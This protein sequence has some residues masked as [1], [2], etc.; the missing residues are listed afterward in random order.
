MVE[1]NQRRRDLMM[2]LS[3][4]VDKLLSSSFS[5]GLL[6]KTH[7]PECILRAFQEYRVYC[8]SFP[9]FL[10]TLLSRSDDEVVRQPLIINLWEES[11]EG[12]LRKTHLKMLDRFLSSWSE[13]I[14]LKNWEI[15]ATSGTV[16]RKF[17]SDIHSY[18]QTKSLPEVFGFIGPGTE[19][20]TTKQYELF[21]KGLRGYGLVNDGDLEFFTTHLV[22]DVRHADLFWD[23]LAAVCVSEDSWHLAQQGASAS[24][25]L[26]IVFWEN[27]LKEVTAS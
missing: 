19:E 15:A 9:K 18:L 5:R 14:G 8:A 7:S 27:L 12:D 6:N 23:A 17:S 2:S 25:D 4:K 13:S 3:P 22:A 24:L 1:L 16:T 26:E 10:G 11:G 20:V 21:V